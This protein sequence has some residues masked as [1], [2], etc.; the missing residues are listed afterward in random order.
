MTNGRLV[1]VA[2]TACLLTRPALALRDWSDVLPPDQRFQLVLGDE[3]VLDKE[4]GLVWSRK[5]IPPAGS[6]GLGWYTA[7]SH[8]FN[9]VIGGRKGWR[10]PTMEE[11]ATL[12]DPA[13]GTPALPPGHP[14]NLPPAP[15]LKVWSV[16]IVGKTSVK[17]PTE[18][19]LLLDV[20]HGTVSNAF[21]NQQNPVWCVR[22]G[23]GPSRLP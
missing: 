21:I 8:C 17:F 11:L 2:L 12:V 4:T 3:G 15:V 6:P 9:D 22:G 16:T 10:V 1:F 14:F 7:T 19:A 18:K 20:T 23:H 13:G 5:L